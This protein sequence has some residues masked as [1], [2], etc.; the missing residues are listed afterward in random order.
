[1]FSQGNIVVEGGS[2]SAIGV[3]FPVQFHYE[4]NG[5]RGD[6]LGHDLMCLYRKFQ[7]DSLTNKPW[8]NDRFINHFLF[9]FSGDRVLLCHSDWT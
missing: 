6:S 7:K 1:M 3:L 2:K 8:D 5:L 9:F 4:I